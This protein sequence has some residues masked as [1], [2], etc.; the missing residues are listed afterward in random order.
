LRH[1]GIAQVYEAGTNEDVGGR[2]PYFAMEYISDAQPIT[3]YA[4]QRQLSTRN[5][6]EL[7][8]NVCDAVHF[9]HT[10][11]VIHRDLKP[12]NILVDGQGQVKV[13][14]FGVART[15]E[16][17][18]AAATQQ[19]KVG[20]LV[21][22]LRY[23]SPEQC[24]ANPHLLD[25]R[26]DVYA[27]GIV[28]YELLSGSFPYDL[29]STPVYEAP[30]VI[31][32]VPPTPL[33]KVNRAL[34]GDLE[35]IVA[36][37]L[38]K[39]PARRYESSSA[40][41]EDIRHYLRSEPILARPASGV[42]RLRKF[43]RRRRIPLSVSTLVMSAAVLAVYF[44]VE[45]RRSAEAAAVARKAA[46]VARASAEAVFAELFRERLDTARRDKSDEAAKKAIADCTK[47]IELGPDMAAPYALRG[48][49][50]QLLEQYSSAWR[51]CNRALEIDPGES[52]ALQ[53]RGFLL[54]QRGQLRAALDSYDK[55]LGG[56]VGLPED[57]YN[58]GRLRRRF[59]D[60][61]LAIQ[62]HERAVALEPSE[63]IVYQGRGVTRRLMGD[64]DGAIEDL[65]RAT[66]LRQ[67][68][69]VQWNLWIWEMH[70]L[71]D[72]PGDRDAAAAALALAAER[73]TSDP[74]DRV[75][76]GI[77]AGSIS[78]DDALQAA[79]NPRDR[80]FAYYY[81]GARA[82]VDGRPV[83]A[84]V[85]FQKCRDLNVYTTDEL[86]FAEWHLQRLSESR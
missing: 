42:Y 43:V 9:G 21:G 6:L 16:S 79:R 74:M 14:D 4:N 7:F 17:D 47:A 30:R 40:L 18:M 46:E 5:R 25:A 33:S 50:H 56:G 39:V 58:R 61:E 26:S 85:Y 57:F 41:A 49:L 12:G 34:R 72:G 19:T 3:R 51:D 68:R 54:A 1:P 81:L 52:L 2:V 31:R 59:G 28:L 65:T 27:L 62:D 75:C 44:R 36:K 78:A 70:M 86:A 45:S 11:G 73:I 77:C 76:I 32:E 37:A 35:T 84:K 22:T 80:A 29:D 15:T 23:M 13:I 83:D 48:R 63:A 8:L 38:E 82:L 10:K 55:G 67:T 66:Q 20:D 60:L 71:R 24:E 53:T 64:V 69:G